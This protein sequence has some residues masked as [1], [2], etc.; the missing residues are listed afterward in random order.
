MRNRETA[1]TFSTGQMEET[2]GR[3]LMRRRYEPLKQRH[4]KSHLRSCFLQRKLP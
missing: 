4:A 1:H 3:F 2:A